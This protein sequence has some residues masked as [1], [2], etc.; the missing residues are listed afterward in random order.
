MTTTG[1][2]TLQHNGV[3]HGDDEPDDLEM[4]G[5][6]GPFTGGAVNMLPQLWDVPDLVSFNADGRYTVDPA[7][8]TALNESGGLY[9]NL[10]GSAA[11]QYDQSAPPD[12]HTHLLE[13]GLESTRY[14][15][16][17]V[18]PE[19]SD[20]QQG[21]LNV[22][23]ATG[24][25]FSTHPGLELAYGSRLAA[26]RQFVSRADAALSNRA[27]DNAAVAQAMILLGGLYYSL[28]DPLKAYKWIMEAFTYCQSLPNYH[29][30]DSSLSE[31][32]PPSNPEQFARDRE[33]NWNLRAMAMIY[34]TFTS[35]AGSISLFFD[36]TQHRDMLYERR[37]WET[38]A[39]ALQ[40]ERD[41]RNMRE[42]MPLRSAQFTVFAAYPAAEVFSR[43]HF[44]EYPSQAMA[45]AVQGSCMT[46]RVM[47]YK[48]MHES[49]RRDHDT[50]LAG[51]GAHAVLATLPPEPSMASL[52]LPMLVWYQN[53]RQSKHQFPSLAD[54]VDP[55][56]SDMA[57]GCRRPNQS[58]SLYNV[59]IYLST[60]AQLH[61]P[62]ISNPNALYPVDATPNA[63]LVTSRHML[64]VVRRALAYTLRGYFAVPPAPAPLAVSPTY[65]QECIH[66]PFTAANPA[67]PIGIAALQPLTM[68]IL[69]V[70]S[71][72]LTETTA[73]EMSQRIA[74][75]ALE[76]LSTLYLPLLDSQART[77]P[78][79]ASHARKLRGLAMAIMRGAGWGQTM[80]DFGGTF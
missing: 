35:L 57:Q 32:F 50:T 30:V 40:R 11:L 48:Q 75:E 54:F 61:G 67:M 66:R 47:R 63:R 6:S 24:V 4:L 34:D 58:R 33:A 73:E 51:R 64:T 43:S 39:D 59:A 1:L 68:Y 27:C 69:I 15:P 5:L 78:V 55:P 9:Y 46:R 14:Q 60:M 72:E 74:R 36:E 16:Y 77:S 18:V 45:I 17:A 37:P 22:M 26:L 42:Q 41:L 23:Y 8:Y 79:D 10:M 2:G 19:E 70:V 65:P 56:T 25:M 44:V 13:M 28:D 20:L 49:R 38:P 52:H 12:L 29:H 62:P 76:D 31:G 21:A 53:L 7:I 71:A 80:V 3:D